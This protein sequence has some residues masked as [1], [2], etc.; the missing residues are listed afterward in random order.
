MIERVRQIHSPALSGEQLSRLR[1]SLYRLDTSIQQPLEEWIWDARAL[2]D[3]AARSGDDYLD[4]GGGA[5]KWRVETLTRPLEDLLERLEP[6]AVT[7]LTLRSLEQAAER[8]DP[9]LELYSL[10]RHMVST[11]AV[12]EK[13]LASLWEEGPDG[14]SYALV[15]LD[16]SPFIRRQLRGCAGVVAMSATL[17]PLEAYRESLGLPDETELLELGTPFP[18]DRR[19]VLVVPRI[20]TT[21]RARARYYDEAAR[22]VTEVAE[23]RAGHY[24]VFTPSF[25]YLRELRERLGGSSNA[26]LLTQE[27]GSSDRE[28]AGLLDELRREDGQTRLLLA[29]Q[30]GVFAEGGRL[31]WCDAQWGDRDLT[32]AALCLRGARADSRAL[33]SARRGA[34]RLSECLHHAR[35]DPCCSGCGAPHPLGARCRSRRLARSALPRAPLCLPFPGG[36]VGVGSGRDSPPQPAAGPAQFLAEH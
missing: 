1:A 18:T 17:R 2:L 27:E 8:D 36:L 23:T 12:S 31:S 22:V 6:L 32:G 21:F 11:I 16:P 5:R 28:R 35:H 14:G 9:L 10:L 3:R 7:H 13:S 20:A 30:G 33:R 15:C 34:R 29:V 26:V 25:A 19:R 4:A 24:G